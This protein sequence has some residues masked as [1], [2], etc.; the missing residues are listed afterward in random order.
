MPPHG[1]SGDRGR[2]RETGRESKW[3][4]PEEEGALPH[5]LELVRE[6]GLELSALV[7]EAGGMRRGDDAQLLQGEGNEALERGEHALEVGL[8]VLGEGLAERQLL[9]LLLER[10]QLL[11][12]VRGEGEHVVRDV[13]GGDGVAGADDAQQ[14]DEG[15]LYYSMIIYL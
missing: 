5:G 8:L 14:L 10:R 4:R 15:L 12:L 6:Q 2:G 13:A 9:L 7:A 3:G 11:D 1:R